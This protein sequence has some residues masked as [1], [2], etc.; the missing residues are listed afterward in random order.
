[1]TP[2]EILFEVV[3]CV[4][5]IVMAAYGFYAT[6]ADLRVQKYG[7]KVLSKKGYVGIGLL[8]VGVVLSIGTDWWKDRD[9]ASEQRSDQQ[10][11]SKLLSQEQQALKQLDDQV[12]KTRVIA[13]DLE[14]QERLSKQNIGATRSVF[15]QTQRTLEPINGFSAYFRL[16]IPRD[17]PEIDAYVRSLNENIVRIFKNGTPAL[18]TPSYSVDQMGSDLPVDIR[19]KPGSA[20]LPDRAQQLRVRQTLET[21]ALDLDFYR[22]A[23]RDEPSLRERII[24]NTK[25]DLRVILTSWLDAPPDSPD[26]LLVVFDL[27]K[28]ELYLDASARPIPNFSVWNTNGKI[29]SVFDLLMSHMVMRPRLEGF[30]FPSAQKGVA[31]V[32]F[33][34][35]MENG[36]RFHLDMAKAQLHKIGNN[37]PIYTC[38][39]AEAFH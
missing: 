27:T 31:L 11:Q 5:S 28:G 14:E 2:K 3:K 29:V 9:E 33:S 16:K 36:R 23:A 25:P 10:R 1:M 8:I 30:T 19:I 20:L 37:A 7:R 35:W 17:Q 18:S 6:F 13:E 24:G 38:D 34:L 12:Q 39:F 21:A 4:A 26:G 15:N 32:S 22:E